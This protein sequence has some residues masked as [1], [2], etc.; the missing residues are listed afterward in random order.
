MSEDRPVHPLVD[1][2]ARERVE[3]SRDADNPFV[4]RASALGHNFTLRLND[5][6]NEVMFSVFADGELLAEFD[7]RPRGWRLPAPG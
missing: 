5:F 1:R 4:F 7:D 3:W 2:L 6:P